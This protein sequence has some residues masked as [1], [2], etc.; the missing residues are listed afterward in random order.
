M[1]SLNV[2]YASHSIKTLSASTCNVK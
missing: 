2:K 1:F